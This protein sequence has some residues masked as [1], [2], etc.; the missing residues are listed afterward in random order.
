MSNKKRTSQELQL[1]RDEALEQYLNREAFQYD[2]NADALYQQYQNRY[3]ELGRNAMKDTM[4]QAAALTGG[5]GSSYA[6]KP[7]PSWSRMR[8]NRNGS[9]SR[10]KKRKL[11]RRKASIRKRIII[12]G[13]PLIR[14]RVKG[15]TL[16][17]LLW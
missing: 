3:Q 4:G 1:L 17:I 12:P 6:I 7:G 8:P 10:K 13:W 15:K 14:E 5:Y 2:L 16:L 11:L 9:S